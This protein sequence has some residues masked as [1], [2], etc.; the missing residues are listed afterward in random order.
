MTYLEIILLTIL[1]VSYGVFT[2][3]Q[4]KPSEGHVILTYCMSIIF[5]PLILIVRVFIGIFHP[6]NV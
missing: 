2:A 6:D 4:T 3:Y 1:W 5:S